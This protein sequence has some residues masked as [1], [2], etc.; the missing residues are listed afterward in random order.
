MQIQKHPPLSQADL[1]PDPLVSQ[2][3]SSLVHHGLR[4]QSR[5]EC[6]FLDSGCPRPRG[7]ESGDPRGRW[8]RPHPA[9]HPRVCEG[10]QL[11]GPR[12]HELWIAYIAPARR[13]DVKNDAAPLVLGPMSPVIRTAAVMSVKGHLS[14]NPDKQNQDSYFSFFD[15]ST[16]TAVIGVLDG[17]GEYGAMVANFIA[18]TLPRELKASEYYSSDLR[19]AILDA[20]KSTEVHLLRVYHHFCTFSGSTLCMVAF[21]G[22][23]FYI[24]NIG[25]SRAVMGGLEE[26]RQLSRDHKGNLSDERA[27]IESCGGR[28]VTKTYEDG[29]VGPPRVYLGNRDLPG[30]AMSRSIGDVVVRRVGVVAEPEIHEYSMQ[31]CAGRVLILA[32]DGLWDFVSNQSAVIT[33]AQSHTAYD[34]VESLV[35]SCL[36]EWRAKS[37]KV[38][39]DITLA[40]MMFEGT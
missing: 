16:D 20:V 25:D 3:L 5:S 34:A 30:L 18:D 2:L 36:R 19:L 17:H 1:V 37:P 22:D 14:D 13:C 7:G 40:V 35:R 24:A 31:E 29:Y 9:L 23:R 38:I 4:E 6:F 39:D 12:Y 26:T 11:V 21:R 27:R 15:E 8:P 10:E 33:A 28:V 32:T